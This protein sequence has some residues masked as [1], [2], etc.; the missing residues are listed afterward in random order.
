MKENRMRVWKWKNGENGSRNKRKVRVDRREQRRE[1]KGRGEEERG[2]KP[3]AV[4]PAILDP[5]SSFFMHR[6]VH[7]TVA[8]D[9]FSFPFSSLPYP[10]ASLPIPPPCLSPPSSFSLSPSLCHSFIFASPCSLF[11]HSPYV[12]LSTLPYLPLLTLTSPC[13]SLSSSSFFSIYLV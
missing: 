4:H 13:S 3:C 2:S 8:S 5:V 10:I 12:P 6:R 11:V 7:S 9:T 1:R